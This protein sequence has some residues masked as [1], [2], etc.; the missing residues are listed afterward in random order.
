MVDIFEMYDKYVRPLYPE[1]KVKV[2]RDNGFYCTRETDTIMYL[3]LPKYYN[4]IFEER[5]MNYINHLYG[6]DMETEEDFALWSILHEVGHYV[7]LKDKTYKECFEE[8]TTEM[9]KYN[10]FEITYREMTL[11][12]RADEF[13]NKTY[14]NIKQKV[15][16]EI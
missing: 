7:D 10:S 11:E 12:K 14:N 4:L 16:I 5:L 1:I 13:A 15:L 3:E 8:Y 9:K 6:L 2:S